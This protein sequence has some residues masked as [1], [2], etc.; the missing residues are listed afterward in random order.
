[1]DEDRDEAR[2]SVGT[3]AK[4]KNPGHEGRD[5]REVGRGDFVK[6]SGEWLEI[7]YVWDFGPDRPHFRNWTVQ[8][9]N[10][11][12]RYMLE[13]ARYGGKTWSWPEAQV[14]L[15]IRGRELLTLSGVGL[16]NNDATAVPNKPCLACLAGAK[17]FGM[18][19]SPEEGKNAVAWFAAAG[20]TLDFACGARGCAGKC[21]GLPRVEPPKTDLDFYER[22]YDKIDAIDGT[23]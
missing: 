1:M 14:R 12:T 10:G 5:V 16:P 23:T 22:L 20:V 9:K 21:V 6:V 2:A 4:L 13:I 3:T 19:F 17:D 7:E 15:S 18:N 8:L 11:Q